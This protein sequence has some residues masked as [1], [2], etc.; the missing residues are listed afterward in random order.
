MATFHG[1]GHVR[2]DFVAF[3]GSLVALSSLQITRPGSLP[4]LLSC[5]TPCNLQNYFPL[6][7]LPVVNLS[8]P[9]R[10]SLFDQTQ[11]CSGLSLSW[12][13]FVACRFH[14]LSNPLH[15]LACFVIK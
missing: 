2:L 8:S 12:T 3:E 4:G 14:Q 6:T 11:T 10:S 5:D 13:I 1:I 15:P 7:D 9:F